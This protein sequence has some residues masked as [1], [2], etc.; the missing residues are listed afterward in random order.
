MELERVELTVLICDR[1]RYLKDLGSQFGLSIMADCWWNNLDHRRILFD[2]GWSAE[3][4]LHNMESLG[5][6]VDSIDTLVLSHAHYD[7]SWG[8]PGLLQEEGSRFNIVAHREITR[9]VYSTR[10]GLR[11]I[12]LDPR[13]LKELPPARLTLIEEPVEI[14]PGVMV[15]GTIPRVTDFERPEEGVAVLH[16]G[17]LVPDPEWD[18]MA[19]VFDMG[20]QGI[21]IVTGC[22]HAGVVNTVLHSQDITHNPRIQGLVGGFHLVDLDEDVR[23]KTVNALTDFSIDHIWSGHCTGWEAEWMLRKRFEDRHR[24]F[25]SGDRIAFER[26]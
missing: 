22:S 10:R 5:I 9:P 25:Y 8:L 2:T 4:L 18:D 1:S 7:H 11:Y 13:P 17:K 20:Q 21:V 15:T 6:A 26:N 23:V 12:G 24:M 16:D 3:P 19:L 14:Y